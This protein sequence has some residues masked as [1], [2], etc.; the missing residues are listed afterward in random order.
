M[1]ERLG[2]SV[3]HLGITSEFGLL[4]KLQNGAQA[5]SQP[6]R[7]RKLLVEFDCGLRM[8]SV[9]PVHAEGRISEL[10]GS[11]L[12]SASQSV[13]RRD[14]SEDLSEGHNPWMSAHKPH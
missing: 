14:R 11:W 3:K 13:A 9:V 12:L 6:G 8:N 10:A 2:R 7:S 1:N 4:F 5:F